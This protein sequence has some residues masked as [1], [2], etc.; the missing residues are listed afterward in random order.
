MHEMMMATLLATMVVAP[1]FLT[2]KVSQD[3]N[4]L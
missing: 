4:E 2:L 1:L 3:K